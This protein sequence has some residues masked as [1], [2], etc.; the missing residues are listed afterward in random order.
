MELS[1]SYDTDYVQV[2]YH[3]TKK[4]AY[5]AMQKYKYTA[6]L[7]ETELYR[8][9]MTPLQYETGRIKTVKVSL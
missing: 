8:R 6:W 4:A 2:S 3:L 5:K 9:G 1:L 7:G